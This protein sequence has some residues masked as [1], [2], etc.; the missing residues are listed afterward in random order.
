MRPGIEPEPAGT[1]HIDATPYTAAL[2]LSYRAWAAPKGSRQHLCWRYCLGVPRFTYS[3]PGSRG[4]HLPSV[5]KGPAC[6]DNVQQA[7]MA[8]LMHAL[9]CVSGGR[10]KGQRPERPGGGGQRVGWGGGGGRQEVLTGTRQACL[11]TSHA[12]PALAPSPQHGAPAWQG[13]H[14]LGE[15][16][17][18]RRLPR[19]LSAHRRV[20]GTTCQKARCRRWLLCGR[21]C[22]GGAW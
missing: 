2:P 21:R 18:P 15:G 22:R 20:S 13:R 8:V 19:R 10:V 4:S 1:A 9:V 6:I 17:P 12:R 16:C 14:Q 3:N 7:G 5:L 11:P